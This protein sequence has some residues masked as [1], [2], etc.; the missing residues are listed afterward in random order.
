MAST[1]VGKLRLKK[2]TVQQRA[3]LKRLPEI[4]SVVASAWRAAWGTRTDADER[5][6]GRRASDATRQ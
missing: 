4:V 3:D 5:C 1:V 6:R 2:V